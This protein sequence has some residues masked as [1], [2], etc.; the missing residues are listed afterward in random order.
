MTKRLQKNLIPVCVLRLAIFWSAQG[1]AVFR[2]ASSVLRDIYMAAVNYT[3]TF[4]Y[5]VLSYLLAKE[6]GE[7]RRLTPIAERG[8]LFTIQTAITR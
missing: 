1:T 3:Y 5:G 8:N 4:I 7:I 6:L 2:L